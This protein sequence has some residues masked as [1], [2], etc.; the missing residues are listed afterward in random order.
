[1]RATRGAS[2]LP[3]PAFRTP[4]RAGWTQRLRFSKRRSHRNQS[5]HKRPVR[6][7]AVVTGLAD[8]ALP[9]ERPS[10]QADGRSADPAASTGKRCAKQPAGRSAPAGRA[11]N[12]LRRLSYL[13][14]PPSHSE[15]QTYT[16]GSQQDRYKRVLSLTRKAALRL[17]AASERGRERVRGKA[18]GPPAPRSASAGV[19]ALL[20]ASQCFCGPRSASASISVQRRCSENMRRHRLLRGDASRSHAALSPLLRWF[21]HQLS[22]QPGPLI[23]N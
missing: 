6:S 15:E 7:S 21:S 23:P 13:Q 11:R 19:G 2:L 8:V 10:R 17:C 9:G 22:E 20:R 5:V 18:R 4:R 3:G 14:V 16:R 12:S 1:M